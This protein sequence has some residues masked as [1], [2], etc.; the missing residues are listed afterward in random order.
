MKCDDDIFLNVPNLLHIL[1]GGTVP[2]YNSTIGLYDQ[3][4]IK[5]TSG[6]NRISSFNKLL[7]GYLFC[8]AKPISDTTS[9]WYSPVYM[10]SGN[11][12]PNY[13]SGTGYVMSMD[14]AV[15]LYNVSLSTQIFHLEDIFLT[16]ICASKIKL[17]PHHN[18]LFIYT[19]LHDLCSLRGMITQHQFTPDGIRKAY[20]FVT[21]TEI[22]CPGP[23]KYFNSRKIKPRRKTCQ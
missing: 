10:F 5:A 14:S 1:L 3:K 21:S 13:L 20:D 8:Q 18:S 15:S 19:K 17:R 7:I 2:I 12:Y 11:M 9:K 6:D 4:T 16:G 22:N 23:D